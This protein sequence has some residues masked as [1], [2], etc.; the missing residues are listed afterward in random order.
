MGNAG[1]YAIPRRLDAGPVGRFAGTGGNLVPLQVFEHPVSLGR[2]IQRRIPP[3]DEI[4]DSALGV[5]QAHEIP[6]CRWW[7]AVDDSRPIHDRP[8][9]PSALR[10]SKF[11]AIQRRY[12]AP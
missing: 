11:S 6:V 12:P 5:A 3:S 10:A 4:L 1:L 9:R 8:K 2:V 7:V